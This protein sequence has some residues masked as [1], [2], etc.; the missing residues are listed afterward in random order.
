M[1]CALDVQHSLCRLAKWRGDVGNA[2]CVPRIDGAA[3]KD[4]IGGVDVHVSVHLVHPRHLRV[5]L[6][7]VKGRRTDLAVK[8]EIQ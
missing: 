2:Q 1:G 8:I 6:P 4:D 7:A 5:G 3:G